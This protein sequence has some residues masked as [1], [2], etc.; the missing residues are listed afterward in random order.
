M[1]ALATTLLVA[2]AAVW[3][4]TATGA[5]AGHGAAPATG[6]AAGTGNVGPV[7]AV[8]IASAAV[9]GGFVFELE[10]ELERG[11]L[12]WEADVASGSREYDVTIAA[13]SGKVLRVVRDRTP[14]A[15]MRLRTAA[16]V[17]PAQAVRTSV[18]AVPGSMLRDLELRRWRGTVA[19]RAEVVTRSGIGYEVVLDAATGRLLAKRV[20]D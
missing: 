18:R 17:L 7:R 4:G 3:A 16:T 5:A 15:G 8:Q 19:W 14:D 12:V 2:C 20:D 1:C 10:L 9:T 13:R 6:V 11:V